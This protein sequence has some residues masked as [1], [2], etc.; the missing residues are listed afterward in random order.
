MVIP[1]PSPGDFFLAPIPGRVGAAIRFGQFLNGE[2]FLPWQHAGILLENG[3]TMEAMPGGAIIGQ[4][5]RWKPEEL[6]WSTGL[7]DLT[8]AQRSDIVHYARTREGVPYS[9]I[10]YAAVA[11]HR[12][13]LPLPWLKKYI[14]SS[15]HQICSQMVDWV[16]WQAGVHL[17]RDRRWPGYVTPASLDMLLDSIEFEKTAQGI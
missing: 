17:F 5:N 2:G 16:Y 6:K 3:E 10:D 12:F 14:S 15:G 13:H 7:V 1:Q 8:A 11:A 9:F 4:I